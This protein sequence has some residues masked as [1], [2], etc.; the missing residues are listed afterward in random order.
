MATTV[1]EFTTPMSEKE[2][3]AAIGQAVSSITEQSNVIGRQIVAT[4][5]RF[6]WVKHPFTNLTYED[7]AVGKP[8]KSLP[9]H[10]THDFQFRIV[11]G[12]IQQYIKIDLSMTVGGRIKGESF[13]ITNEDMADKDLTIEGVKFEKTQTRK[14]TVYM[15]FWGESHTFVFFVAVKDGMTFDTPDELRHAYMTY[16]KEEASVPGL[17]GDFQ[18]LDSA[19]AFARHINHIKEQH[20]LTAVSDENTLKAIALLY[21]ERK[22][23]A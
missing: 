2:L 23:N 16:G 22:A 4:T 10:T 5:D 11:D 19:R 8:F 17:R 13:A 14:G 15:D 6:V 18:K 21:E 7:K 9:Y 20:G 3:K 12:K 1:V